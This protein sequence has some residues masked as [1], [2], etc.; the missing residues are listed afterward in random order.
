MF[1]QSPYETRGE[2][3]LLVQ[4]TIQCEVFF[5]DQKHKFTVFSLLSLPT[6]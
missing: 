3:S 4:P 2:L 5:F 1:E 6:F